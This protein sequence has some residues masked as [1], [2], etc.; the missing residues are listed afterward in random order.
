MRSVKVK[1]TQEPHAPDTDTQTWGRGDG[2]TSWAPRDA[3]SAVRRLLKGLR[4]TETTIRR[5]GDDRS[6]MPASAA[7]GG[8]VK[9]A[10]CVGRRV[11]L[12]CDSLSMSRG[13]SG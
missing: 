12:E 8:C 10:A 13:V 5:I 4:R 7:E 2:L 1:A 6:A 9:R 3:V 11:E